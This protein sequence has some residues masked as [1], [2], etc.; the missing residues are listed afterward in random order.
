MESDRLGTKNQY[1]LTSKLM[2]E[3]LT[4]TWVVVVGVREATLAQPANGSRLDLPGVHASLANPTTTDALCSRA[5]EEADQEAF[6]FVAEIQRE[7]RYR[8]TACVIVMDGRSVYQRTGPSILLHS[9]TSN[10]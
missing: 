8:Q 4:M 1:A 9:I 5:L 10:K 6:S 3:L 2:N 7:F